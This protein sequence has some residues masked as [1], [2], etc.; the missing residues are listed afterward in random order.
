MARKK[1]CDPSDFGVAA[2]KFDLVPLEH[3]LFMVW[4]FWGFRV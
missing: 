4:G 1:R 3:L 2:K